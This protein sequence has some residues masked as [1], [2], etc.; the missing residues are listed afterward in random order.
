MNWPLQQPAASKN[1]EPD[2]DSIVQVDMKAGLKTFMVYYMITI[3]LL[4]ARYPL[5]QYIC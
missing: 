1:D 4:Y 3:L 2:N 5:N